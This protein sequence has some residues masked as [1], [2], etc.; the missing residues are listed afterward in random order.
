MFYDQGYRKHVSPV[1]TL[2]VRDTTS[3][4]GAGLRWNWQRKLDVS[5]TYANV[6]NGVASGTPSGHDQLLFS[7]FYRF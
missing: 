6:L 2:P 4:I 3:S 1:P 5:V 7:A